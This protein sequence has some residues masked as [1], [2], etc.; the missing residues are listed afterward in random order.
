M[1]AFIVAILLLP[2]SAFAGQPF[3]YYASPAGGYQC[4]GYNQ[5]ACIGFESGD[6][7]HYVSELIIKPNATNPLSF[8]VQLFFDGDHYYGGFIAGNMDKPF[9]VSDRGPSPP[10]SVMLSVHYVATKHCITTNGIL[11]CKDRYL[12]ESGTISIP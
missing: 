8:S 9:M 11:H 6:P 12:P 5:A 4:G 7:A 10:N 2:A 1:K 3:N